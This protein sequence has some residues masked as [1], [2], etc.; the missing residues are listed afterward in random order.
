MSHYLRVGDVPRKRH[1]WHRGAEG[2]RLAE[3]LMG[4]EG[5]NGASSLLYHRNSPS[6]ITGVEPFELERSPLTANDPLLPW[7]LQA[8]RA[9]AGGDLVTGRHLLLGNATVNICWVDADCSSDLYRN[10]AG[11]EVV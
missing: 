1:T 2:R 7:H 3:E 11:D 10:A 8:P 5:F 6:A 4:E 9:P